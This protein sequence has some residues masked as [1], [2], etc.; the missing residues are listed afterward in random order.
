MIE[1]GMLA[2]LIVTGILLFFLRS[3]FKHIEALNLTEKYRNWKWSSPSEART[4]YPELDVFK[5]SG[6][7]KI[8]GVMVA[9]VMMIFAFSWTSYD[10]RVDVSGLLGTLDEVIEMETPR[11]AEPPP[12]PPPPPP[13]VQVIATDLPDIKTRIFED[14][15]ISE[16]TSIEVPVI[17]KKETT[18]PPPPPPPPPPAEN[19]R[20][21]FKVVEDAP[22]FPG[23]ADIVDKPERQKCA[24]TKLLE[25][26]YSKIQYPTIARENG[27]EGMVY[28][29]FVVERDGRISNI[30]VVRDVGGGCGD[31]A[32][33]VVKL[34]PKWNPGKQRGTPVRVMFTLPVKFDLQ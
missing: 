4:K 8:Y 2:I 28:V 33:R 7:L 12:P 1:L 11:T 26:I 25:F 34:M 20:E 5:I 24:E 16:E 10:S 21:I 9:L 14:Q 19:E 6:S 23:C 17:I 3:H 27:I 32:A 29:R 30:E 31:E 22:T 13:A 18:A 15:S